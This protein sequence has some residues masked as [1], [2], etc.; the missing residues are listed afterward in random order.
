MAVMLTHD[1]HEAIGYHKRAQLLSCFLVKKPAPKKSFWISFTSRD[2]GLAALL[3]TLLL[4]VYAPALNGGLLWDDD[5]HITRPSLQS[6]SGLASIW[7]QPGATQ[8]YYPLL[9]SAFWLEH[10]LWGDSLF[11]YHLLNLFLHAA[12]AF[13]LVAIL[14]RLSI[15]GAWLA[16]FLFALH[17]VQVETVAWISEQKNALSTVFY[18]ASAF[19]YLEF[20]RTRA[21]RSY[22]IA[23]ALF[24]AALLSKSVTATL[25][26]A[27]LVVLW[28]KRG[29]LDWK[30]DAVQLLPWL[31]AGALGGLFTAHFEQSVIGA[32]GQMYALTLAQKTLLAGRILCFYAGKLFWPADLTF[33]YPHWSIDTHAASGYLFLGAVL[34]TAAA[35]LALARLLPQKPRGPLAGFLFFA[36][37]LAPVLGFLNVYPFRFSYVA[38]HFQYVACLGIFVPMAPG[39][40]MVSSK[41]SGIPARADAWL[42]PAVIA[43][44]AFLTWNQ[45]GFYRDA[46]TLYRETIANNPDSWM[47]HSNLGG[48]L[49]REP[50][51]ANEAMSQLETALQLNPDLPEAHNNVGLLLSNIPGETKDAIKE[52][53][54]A[55]QLRPN[56]AE[57]HNNLGSVL[58]DDPAGIN[59]AIAEYQ[60]A[61]RL[62][63]EYASAHNNLGSAYSA[64]GRSQEAMDEFETALRLDPSLAEAHANLGVAL[65][66]MPGRGQQGVVELQTALRLRPDMQRVRQILAQVQS[67]SNGAAR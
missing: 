52:F 21:R 63:P 42:G 35:L 45:T 37:T 38:D 23:F 12:S 25:P 43:A 1:A 61:L 36:G 16:A 19:V 54:D 58:A 32:Q 59:D 57:A 67:Q 65:L 24:L 33:I 10:G 17:P 41:L 62:S 14:R 26:A 5:A 34:V 6:F 44:L 22:W 15:P 64:L 53:H 29:K 7:F 4:F 8:Q 20:D 30:T 48:I 11:G 47:A 39:L 28:W 55:L 66:K 2:L 51:R 56:Y 50:G 3:L 18:L 40:A 46:E 9:H 27:L 31:A 60:E 49:M 13:L